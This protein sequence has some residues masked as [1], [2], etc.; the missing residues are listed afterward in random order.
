MTA[1]AESHPVD[2]P[3]GLLT[4]LE[5]E[6]M[7]ATANLARLM[8]RIIGKTGPAASGDCAEMVDKIHQLQ[9][10]ILAQAASRA[11]P[12]RFRKLGG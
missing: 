9:L 6:A 5:L 2:Q 11:Y 4:D 3:G 7:D 10:M 1:I 12:D 8:F